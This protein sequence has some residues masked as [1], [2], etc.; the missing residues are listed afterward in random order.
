M[1]FHQRVRGPVLYVSWRGFTREDL[2]EVHYA[3]AELR[4]TLQRGAIYLSRIPFDSKMFS[5]EEQTVLL[6]FLMGIL[7]SC[8]TIHHVVEGEGFVKSARRALVTNMALATPRARDFYTHST[9]A[10]AG[11][12]I[13]NL[14]HIDIQ[15]IVSRT[16]IAPPESH[17]AARAFREAAR[18]AETKVRRRG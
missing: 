11:T 8:Q 2:E 17:R 13:E 7:P 1:P 15:D 10:E 18:I 14:H 4:G 9:M 5:G 12:I 6:D 16:S 3:L